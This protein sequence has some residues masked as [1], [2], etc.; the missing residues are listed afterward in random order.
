MLSLVLF[1]PKVELRALMIEEGTKR[2]RL[3]RKCGGN[4][5]YPVS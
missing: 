3:G 5:L 2:V 4:A 1:I